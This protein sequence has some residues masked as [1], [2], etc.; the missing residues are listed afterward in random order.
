[1]Q[2]YKNKGSTEIGPSHGEKMRES[3]RNR[4]QL[5]NQTC[6]CYYC[7]RDFPASQIT[8]WTDNE[9]TAVCPFCHVDAVIPVNQ[10]LARQLNAKYFG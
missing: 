7:L 3:L 1:M 4:K 9:E 5:E 2:S 6:S 8:Q 10:L